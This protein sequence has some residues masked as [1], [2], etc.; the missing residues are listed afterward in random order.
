MRP[1]VVDAAVSLLESLQCRCLPMP[2][3]DAF[4]FAARPLVPEAGK[5]ASARLPTSIGR[6]S[7][8]IA[9]PHRLLLGV[10]E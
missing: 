4:A 9:V 7:T 10:G 6:I 1:C 8:A 5:R 2:R 3:A